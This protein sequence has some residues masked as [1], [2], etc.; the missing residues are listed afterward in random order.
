MLLSPDEVYRNPVLKL[1]WK[2]PLKLCTLYS[3]TRPLQESARQYS[4]CFAQS[5][6]NVFVYIL[7]LMMLC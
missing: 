5:D 4:S 1:S 3:D 2:H 7:G 6:F